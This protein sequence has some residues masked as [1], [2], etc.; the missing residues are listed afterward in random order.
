MSN[1]RFRCLGPFE[2]PVYKSTRHWKNHKRLYDP[3]TATE[4]VFSQ[5]A[6][7]ERRIGIDGINGA[8]GL[9]VIGMKPRG[10][11]IPFY[12]GQAARQTIKARIFQRQDKLAKVIEILN[13]YTHAKPFVFLF[14]LLTPSG[15]L[16]KMPKAGVSGT[17]NAQRI[18]TSAE[19]MMIGHAMNVNPWLHNISTVAERERFSIDGS[20]GSW[21]NQTKDARSYAEMM[22]FSKAS[23]ASDKLREV[24][25]AIEDVKDADT[26]L[27]EEAL[28]HE[29]S[30]E[31]EPMDVNEN[32]GGGE[33]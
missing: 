18:I 9:Y 10:K 14:P 8:I 15:R 32:G 24:G 30:L 21:G 27:I 13:I 2:F 7:E 11:L 26:Q 17:S 25:A 20:P 31:E 1:Y 12:V 22:G 19:Y 29:E 33:Q 4:S 28:A 16:A 6:M 3:K 5:A 23:S